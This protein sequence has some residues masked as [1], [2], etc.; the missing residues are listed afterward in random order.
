MK[1]L[2]LALMLI[3]T[4][5]GIAQTFN[6]SFATNEDPTECPCGVDDEGNCLPCD[7]DE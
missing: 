2:L 7:E 3:V 1:K 5:L 6:M 4:A